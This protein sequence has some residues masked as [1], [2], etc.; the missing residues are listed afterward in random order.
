MLHGRPDADQHSAPLERHLR[1]HLLV[2]V[3]TILSHILYV[4][5]AAAL[6]AS[7]PASAF[8]VG[9]G[10]FLTLGFI[11]LWRYGW[12]LINFTRAH[13]YIASAYPRLRRRAEARY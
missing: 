1:R 4:L 8:S 12:A 7:V 2:S 9:T 11:G 10:V 6:V 5:C 13:L 3:M